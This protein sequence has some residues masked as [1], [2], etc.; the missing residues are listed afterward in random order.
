M[1]SRPGTMNIDP[2]KSGMNPFASGDERVS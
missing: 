2:S 1:S